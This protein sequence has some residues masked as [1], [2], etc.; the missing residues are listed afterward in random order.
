MFKKGVLDKQLDGFVNVKLFIWLK[1]HFFVA[2]SLYFGAGYF[3]HGEYYKKIKID[4]C[5]HKPTV[6]YFNSFNSH[7]KNKLICLALWQK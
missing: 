5:G 3:V 6:F 7:L 2:M 1:L 4:H